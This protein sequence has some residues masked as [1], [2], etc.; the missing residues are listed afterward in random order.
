MPVHE[1][2]EASTDLKP[3]PRPR[4]REKTGVDGSP[5]VLWVGR[6]HPRKDPITAIRL[7]ER[8]IGLLPAARLHLV[9]GEETLLGEIR[10]IVSA[11]EAL[12]RAVRFVGRVAH[13]KLGSWCSA[14]D[15]FLTTSPA[16]GSNWALIEATAC[17]LPAVAS[18]IPAHRRVAG[19]LAEFFRTGDT[20][21]GAEA[22]VRASNRAA[23]IQGEGWRNA[24]RARFEMCLSWDVVAAEAA[25]A[26]LSAI[27][28][29]Q[30]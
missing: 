13:E 12:S 3:V 14:S 18:A 26:Y 2:L 24:L 6:L 25:R 17:G 21:D 29:R 20:A 30:T 8:A 11:S 7:F 27:A 23:G 9:Y 15:L 22:L 19:D 16:E 10:S 4:A 1:V 5:A 28:R